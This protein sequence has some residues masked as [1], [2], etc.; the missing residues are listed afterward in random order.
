MFNHI[1]L[2]TGATYTGKGLEVDN[3][4]WRERMGVSQELIA[5]KRVSVKL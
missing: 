1:M 4:T 5:S 3:S 2:I